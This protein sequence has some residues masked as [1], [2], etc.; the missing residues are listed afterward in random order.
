MKKHQHRYKLNIFNK[1]MFL[2]IIVVLNA[3]IM[4]MKFE[5]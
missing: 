1:S 2:T 3:D 5:M 4:F